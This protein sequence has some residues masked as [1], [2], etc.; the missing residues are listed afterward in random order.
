MSNRS[1]PGVTRIPG[2]YSRTLLVRGMAIWALARLVV[3][4][5]YL[6][7]ASSA[8]SE[9]AAAFT[10]GSPVILALW[11]L[12]LSAALVRVDLHR[13]HEVSLLNNLGVIT[14]HAILVGTVPAVVM[15][16]VLARVR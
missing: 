3:H 12:V 4:A 6:I 13:R 11:S 2:R 1:T 15:E 16:T 9:T 7:I 8:D 10:N 5:L 14:L